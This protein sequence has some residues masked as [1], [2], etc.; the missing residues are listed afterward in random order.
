MNGAMLLQ[1]A[2]GV[3]DKRRADYGEPE[4]LFEHIAARWVAG[5]RD[6]GHRRPG[7]GLLDGP[8]DGPARPRP[9]APRQPGRRP[10]LRRVLAGGHPVRWWPEGYGGERRPADE[11]KREGWREQ[12]ILVIAAEDGR[13]T[14]PER[15]LVRRLG[16]K[17]YG[18]QP[19]EPRA[20]RG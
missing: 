13:L 1:H 7:R 19:A 9:E 5:A 18:P 20:A 2:A 17:L 14:W 6:P 12:G 3:V 15:E 11:I 8:Q 16:E 10:R 4:D